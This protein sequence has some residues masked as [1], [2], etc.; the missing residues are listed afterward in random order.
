ITDRTGVPTDQRADVRAAAGDRS[1]H[2]PD[3]ADHSG[4]DSEQA[5]EFGAEGNGEAADGLTIAVERASKAVRAAVP[6]RD[7]PRAAVPVRGARAIDVLG[8]LPGGIEIAAGAADALL[9]V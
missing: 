4:R 8:E 5:S 2:E 7:E 9:G 3:I 1:S 6:D